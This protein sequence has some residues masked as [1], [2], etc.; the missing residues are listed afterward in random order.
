[1]KENLISLGNIDSQGYKYSAE[2]GVLRVSKGV[3]VAMKDSAITR[4]WHMGLRHMSEAD[5]TILRVKF[6]ITTHRI[7]GTL[8]YIHSDLWGPTL[9]ESKRFETGVKGYHLWCI[10]PE[11][12]KFIISKDVKFDEFVMLYEK[13]EFVDTNTNHGVSKRIEL[14][15][16]DFDKVQDDTLVQSTQGD[17]HDYE[18]FTYREVVNGTESSQWVIAISEEIES[19]HKNKTWELVKPPKALSPKSKDDEEQMFRVSYANS[20]GSMM[21][22][23]VCTHSNISHVVSVVSKFM[24]SPGKIHWEAVKWIFR[25][26]KSTAYL[27]FVFGKNNTT[28]NIIGYVDTVY[29]GDLDKM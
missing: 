15:V 27:G 8:N 20:V 4:L 16:E 11:S 12:Q 14:E 2:C 17:V 18:P 19:L 26:L 5:M 3:L 13:K 6:T 21:Y 1:M 25:Y 9:D 10:K 7:N 28:N 24:G 23:M 22:A 29:A